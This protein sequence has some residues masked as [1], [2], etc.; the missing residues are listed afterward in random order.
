MNS[1]SRDSDAP[2]TANRQMGSGGPRTGIC[3]KE[4]N[5]KDVR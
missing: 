5:G 4:T 2:M 1:L 3:R